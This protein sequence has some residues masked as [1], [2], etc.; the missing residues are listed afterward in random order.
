VWCRWKDGGAEKKMKKNAT[1][2]LSIYLSLFSVE[3]SLGGKTAA[4]VCTFA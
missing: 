3:V 1:L 2:S 4:G